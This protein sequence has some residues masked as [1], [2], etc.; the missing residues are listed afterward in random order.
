[1]ANGARPGATRYRSL[2]KPKLLNGDNSFENEN[3]QTANIDE[4]SPSARGGKG[5]KNL[6]SLNAR[7]VGRLP[8]SDDSRTRQASRAALRAPRPVLL[9]PGERKAYRVGFLDG[10]ERARRHLDELR[11]RIAARS[12]H[13]EPPSSWSTRGSE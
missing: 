10:V 13:C 11:I 4:T 6:P 12:I 8:G 1:M 9:T 5:S 7:D 3:S 2:R